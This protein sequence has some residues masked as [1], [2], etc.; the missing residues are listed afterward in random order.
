ME[1]TLEVEEN[2]SAYIKDLPDEVRIGLAEYAAK[3]YLDG[4]EKGRNLA[5]DELLRSSNPVPGMPG[6][7]CFTDAGVETARISKENLVSSQLSCSRK[8]SASSMTNTSKP[9]L[10]NLSGKR[11]WLAVIRLSE[12][13]FGDARDTCLGFPEST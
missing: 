5:V 12:H 7:W 13:F 10:I 2:W 3:Q 9:K 4:I 1:K 8:L 6:C 11:W